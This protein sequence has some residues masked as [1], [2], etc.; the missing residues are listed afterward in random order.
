MNASSRTQVGDRPAPDRPLRPSE[1][2][3]RLTALLDRID[4]QGLE[5]LDD[6]DVEDLG[7][8]YRATAARLAHQRAFGASTVREQRLN[9]LVTRAHA[10]VYGRPQRRPFLATLSYQVMAFPLTIRRTW[11]YHVAAGAI[12]VLAGVYGY[13]GSAEDPDWTR[14]FT[15]PGDERTPYATEAELLATLRDGR[16]MGSGR[17]AAFAA[18]L[19]QNNTKVALIAYFLGFLACVPTVLALGMNGLMLGTYSFT[20][21]QKGLAYEWWAWILPHGITEMLSIVLLA[22]GGL[23]VGHRV[24]APGERTRAEALRAVRADAVRLVCFAF[25]LLFVAALIESFV[26]QSHLTD[27]ARYVFAGLTALFWI[28][29]L[30]FVRPTRDAVEQVIAPATVAQRAVPLPTEDELLG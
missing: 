22:G 15:F 11:P 21:H 6:R 24:I 4:A 8:L 13:F 23:M 1:I 30:G 7:K 2:E 12:L 16:E 3:G 9:A 10:V 17:K 5:R 28:G 27:G 19:W 26:R 18:Q 14:S 29:Y 25:P 20:F